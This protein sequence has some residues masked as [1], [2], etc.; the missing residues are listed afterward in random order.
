M[1]GYP[2]PYGNSGGG[3]PSPYNSG[4][5]YA[6]YPPAPSAMPTPMYGDNQSCASLYGT[7]PPPLPNA[8]NYYP[9]APY[10]GSQMP[11]NSYGYG[12]N[13]GY[14]PPVAQHHGGK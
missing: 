8:N 10:G 5:G 3:Y 2:Y 13:G 11:D 1:S 4:G 14:P 6:N 12:G 9:P 7:A